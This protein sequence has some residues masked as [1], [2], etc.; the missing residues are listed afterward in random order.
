[1]HAGHTVQWICAHE[2]LQGRVSWDAD[3]FTNPEPEKFNNR[4]QSMYVYSPSRSVV[5][6]YR[7]EVS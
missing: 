5:A 2:I 1:M 7:T 6:F 4:D 3:H